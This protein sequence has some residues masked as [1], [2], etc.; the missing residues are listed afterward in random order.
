MRNA[1]ITLRVIEDKNVVA[2]RQAVER[3]KR[4]AEVQDR[5]GMVGVGLL[6]LVVLSYGGSS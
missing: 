2:Q 1:K 4:N 3:G 5:V 6:L